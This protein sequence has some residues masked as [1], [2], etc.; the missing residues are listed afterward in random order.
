MKVLVISNQKGGVGKTTTA[1]NLA[2]S[3]VAINKKVVIIDLDPQ[4]NATTGLN[5]PKNKSSAN[6]YDLLLNQ[7]PFEDIVRETNIPG[8]YIIPATVDLAVADIDLSLREN[9]E[10]Y[11]RS[12]LKDCHSYNY[13]YIIIDCAPGFGL[14]SLNALVAADDVL[15]PLQAEFYALEGLVQLLDN[16]KKIRKRFNQKLKINGILI[17]MFDSRNRLCSSILKDVKDHFPELLYNVYIPRNVKISEA[18]SYGKPVLI[19]DFRCPGSRAY[20]ELA[21]EFLSREE[22]SVEGPNLNESQD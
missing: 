15:I 19:Y 9:R 13:D 14:V 8:L 4:G 3:L 5:I 10:S 6:S 7:K 1:I 17:T 18:P 16:I 11:L 21:K 22:P 20:I 2:T 12:A